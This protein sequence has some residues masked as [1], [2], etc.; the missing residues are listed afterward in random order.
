MNKLLPIFILLAF[1]A[2]VSAVNTP[3]T[4]TTPVIIPATAYANTALNAS[5]KCTDID[6]GDVLHANFTWYKN[7]AAV[8]TWDT[9][10]ACTNNTLCYIADKNKQPTGLV[11]GDNWTASARCYDGHE[12]STDWVNSTDRIVSNS[13]PLTSAGSITPDPAQD[14]DELNAS[15]TC[16]DLDADSLTANFTWYQNGTPVHT[17]DTQVSCVNATPCYTDTNVTGL[18]AGDSWIASGICNDGTDDSASWENTSARDIGASV[19]TACGSYGPGSYTFS[20]NITETN[21]GGACLN[22]TGATTLDCKGHSL[23][24]DFGAGTTGIEA[25]GV[26][27]TLTNCTITGYADPLVLGAVSNIDHSTFVGD[28][29][30][31]VGPLYLYDESTF[32]SNDLTCVDT[33]LV[34]CLVLEGDTSDYPTVEFNRIYAGAMMNGIRI[35]GGS[36]AL[37]D[38]N[39][40]TGCYNSIVFLTDNENV[41]ITNNHID[42][43]Y[44]NP[45]YGT[46]ADCNMTVSNNTADGI[47]VLYANGAA[48]PADA[49]YAQIIFCGVGADGS[50]I[51]N[52]DASPYGIVIYDAYN[53]N[54][55]DVN[56][57]ANAY[58]DCLL[59]Q[60]ADFMNIT[61]FRCFDAADGLVIGDTTSVWIDNAEISNASVYGITLQ[62]SDDLAILNSHLTGTNVGMEFS[63]G[64]QLVDAML[65]L[66]NTIDYTGGIAIEMSYSPNPDTL[67]YAWGNNTFIGDIS[68]DNQQ[69]GTYPARFIQFYNNTWRNLGLAGTT[70]IT[71]DACGN[72]TLNKVRNVSES[73][74]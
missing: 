10:V 5:T 61:N 68:I 16:T 73:W 33:S 69:D 32:I 26:P 35:T 28:G 4:T 22:F 56:I 74:D 8:H 58:S 36:G 42:G 51:T 12:Y 40:I 7:G 44:L 72:F 38:S 49:N 37:I 11:K 19:I 1:V 66:N 6:V 55:T 34:A 2:V 47:D 43:A 67:L 65:L 52:V 71:I 29:Q 50:T 20:A 45:L 41:T 18:V 27:L 54:L 9:Q 24:G 57:T 70:A 23:T 15:M 30:P 63:G 31:Q 48:A 39:T 14:F 17:Y 59:A 64:V 21:P 13:I 60:L 25:D 62:E 53:V 3:P 46:M